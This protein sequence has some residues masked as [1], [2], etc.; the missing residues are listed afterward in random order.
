MSQMTRIERVR[1][2]QDLHQVRR[3]NILSNPSYPTLKKDTFLQLGTRQV[4]N[5]KYI[6]S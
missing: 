4:I 2:W 3:R 6:I 1:N 5:I